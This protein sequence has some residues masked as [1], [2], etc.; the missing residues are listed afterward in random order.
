[1]QETQAEDGGEQKLP[2]SG[3]EKN[4]QTS[5]VPRSSSREPL[6]GAILFA[7]MLLFVIVSVFGVGWIA[8]TKWQS[9][10]IAKSHPSITVL[11][12]QS[13]Q[14]KN[15]A[16]VEPAKTTDSEK[17]GEPAINDS[18]AAVKKL[19]ITVLNGGGAKGSAGVLADFLK[20]EGYS[21]TD[22][23]NTVKDYEGVV[24]YY[25]AQLEKEALGVKGSVVKKYPQ[26]KILPADAKNKET[27]V[28]QV[29][30]IL[31]K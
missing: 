27:A 30:I 14:E 28:S 24:I 11:S 31:G 23:G 29:T 6:W 10:R 2:L 18:M 19:E 9:E 16:P 8:Y 7:G 20:K 17:A 13:K 21:K 3:K 5:D 15:V 4:S 1:M 12:E 26:A 22:S 25:A